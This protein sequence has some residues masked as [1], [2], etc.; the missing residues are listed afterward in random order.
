M[1]EVRK[2]LEEQGKLDTRVITIDED[3]N[4]K[5]R[6]GD[7]R[8]SSVASAGND[9]KGQ[10]NVEAKAETEEQQGTVIDLLD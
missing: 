9:T 1:L 4:W 2:T 5:P 3:G 6:D 8:K 10:A 7:S